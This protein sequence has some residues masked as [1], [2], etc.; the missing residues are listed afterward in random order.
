MWYESGLPFDVKLAEN[1]DLVLARVRSKKASMIIIDGLMG[2][3]K[4]TEA[5]HVADYLNGAYEKIGVKQWKFNPA[6]AIDLETQYSMGGNKF[7]EN[8]QIGMEKQLSVSLYDEGGDFNKRGS[9]T[10]FNQ[11]LNRLFDTY[12][13]FAIVPIICLPNAGVI[14]RELFLKGVP[15]MMIH[16]ENRTATYGRYRAYSLWRYMF[17]LQKMQKSTVP[18][19]AYVRT[20]PNFYGQFKDLPEERRALLEKIGKEGKKEILTNNVLKSR[21]LVSVR[22]M[23]RRLNLSTQH[24]NKLIRETGVKAEM[25]YKKIRYFHTSAIDTLLEAVRQK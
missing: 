4:T 14:D 18:Q 9:L 11:Q 15:R 8:I 12:R 1:L 19:Q 22:D 5:V 24:T 16:C 25:E 13:A 20:F 3:G 10:A 7:L 2:E 23:S 6:K 21:G 17:V